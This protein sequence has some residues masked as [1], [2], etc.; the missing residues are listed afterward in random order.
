MRE[1]WDYNTVEF[2]QNEILFLKITL[3]DYLQQAALDIITILLS[4]SLTTILSLQKEDKIR[5]AL[6]ELVMILKREE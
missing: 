4:L 1:V 2:F 6:L 5:N 3:K